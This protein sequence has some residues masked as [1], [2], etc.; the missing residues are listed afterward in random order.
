MC[1]SGQI[2]N[3]YEG[4]FREFDEKPLHKKESF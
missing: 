1:K 4:G 3:N 2:N